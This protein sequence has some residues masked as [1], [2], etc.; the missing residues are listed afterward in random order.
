LFVYWI[1]VEM[2][3]GVIALPLRRALPLELSL[4]GTVLLCG[5][6]YQLVRVKDRLMHGVALTGPLRILTPVLR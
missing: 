5:L 1:H 2:A 3:Y 4:L 6:L